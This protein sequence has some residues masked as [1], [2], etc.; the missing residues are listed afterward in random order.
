[1]K[2]NKAKVTFSSIVSIG[3][4]VGRLEKETGEKYL[5]LHRGVMDVTYLNMDPSIYKAQQSGQIDQ[6]GPNDG[7]PDLLQYLNEDMPEETRTLVTPGGMAA[8]DLVIESMD[9]KTF[10]VPKFHWGSWNKILTTHDKEIKTYDDFQLSNFRPRGGVVMLC[11]PSNPTGYRPSD[12]EIEDFLNYAKENNIAVLLDLPYWDLLCD[13][14]KYK[15]FISENVVIV[16]SYSKSLGLSG[17]RVG[18]VS[19]LS[20]ELYQSMRVRSLYKYNSPA[21]IT[22]YIV[23]NALY[24]RNNM[25]EFRKE[26]ADHIRRNIDFLER[27]GLLYDGYPSTPVGPFAIVNISYD[28][29]MSKKISS[30]PMTSFTIDKDPIYAGLSRISVAVRNEKFEEY[31]A[32]FEK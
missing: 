14:G 24:E 28:E 19:T 22:Q 15:R 4:E 31:L 29:L 18:S 13:E 26:T 17:Y 25:L 11:V 12:K 21:T 1:M 16:S 2:V 30:V 20:E 8:L 32:P 10:Y 23:S 9:Y 5:K 7:W 27:N 6:Y 3:E